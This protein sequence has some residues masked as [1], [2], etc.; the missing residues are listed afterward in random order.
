VEH[1]EQVVD[2]QNRTRVG[3]C[4]IITPPPPEQH[5]QQFM[6]SK[7]LDIPGLPRPTNMLKVIYGKNVL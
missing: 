3:P 2:E 5:N 7:M 6:A 4:V 1:T